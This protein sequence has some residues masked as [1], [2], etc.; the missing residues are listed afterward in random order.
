LKKIIQL[1][2]I[3]GQIH[4]LGSK[5]FFGIPKNKLLMFT[6]FHFS[7][8]FDFKHLLMAFL[9]FR[10][11]SFYFLLEQKVTKI[12]VFIKI[13]C[14]SMPEVSSRNTRHESWHN[15]KHLSLL[16]IATHMPFAHT[17]IK[18]R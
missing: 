6:I 3:S 5:V 11:Y 7:I 14:V 4:F 16:C 2:L 10:H 9:K 18:N 8:L 15:T 12:Q 13:C 17:S 1:K